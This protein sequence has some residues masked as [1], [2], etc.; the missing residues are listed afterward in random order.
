MR[1]AAPVP[2]ASG[3]LTGVIIGGEAQGDGCGSEPGLSQALK[4]L[5][6]R[7]GGNAKIP[8]VKRLR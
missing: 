2:W 5:V 8:T 1:H 4:V 6:E 3:P 7:K